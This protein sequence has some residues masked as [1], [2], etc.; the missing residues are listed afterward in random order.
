MKFVWIQLGLQ[1]LLEGYTLSMKRIKEIPSRYE[2]HISIAEL[3]QEVQNL[4][5][6]EAQRD[7]SRQGYYY[8][9]L[10]PHQPYQIVDVDHTMHNFIT[11]IIW[12]Q[13]GDA[14][15]NLVSIEHLRLAAKDL[16]DEILS[17]VLEC[18]YDK[19]SHA[20]S[21]YVTTHRELQ[22]KLAELGFHREAVFLES[23][24]LAWRAWKQRG[25]TFGTRLFYISRGCSDRLTSLVCQLT[26]YSTCS[27]PWT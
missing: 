7:A 22:A 12:G 19:H 13:G 26:S 20:C 21:L 9:R 8:I 23:L 24:G 2:P 3:D 6:A 16:Y 25:L 11:K 4:E 1:A 27:R 10:E 14:S 18:S 5:V 15:L 17:K